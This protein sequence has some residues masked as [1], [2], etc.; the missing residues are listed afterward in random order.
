MALV[1]RQEEAFRLLAVIQAQVSPPPPITIHPLDVIAT[2]LAVR[3][4]QLGID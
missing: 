4:Q 1:A 3:R 2:V